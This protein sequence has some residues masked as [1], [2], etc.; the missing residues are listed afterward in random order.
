M[1][2]GDTGKDMAQLMLRKG[3]KPYFA[4]ATARS[5]LE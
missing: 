5:E 2:G 3:L 4:Y 1:P